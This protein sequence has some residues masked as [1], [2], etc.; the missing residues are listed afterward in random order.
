MDATLER[1]QAT[2]DR[3]RQGRLSLSPL[4]QRRLANFKANRRGYWSLW[5][6]LVLFVLSLF[7]ELLANDKPIV[8]GFKGELYFPMLANY[9]EETFL[10]EDGFLP[11]TDYKIARSQP[12]STSMAGRSG[13]RSAIPTAP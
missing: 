6:F 5:I 7:A 12:R 1:A 11:T 8:V 4:N 9:P 13:R 10:G 2:Q 3:P